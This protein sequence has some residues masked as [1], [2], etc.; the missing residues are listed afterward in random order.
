MECSTPV[1]ENH[2]WTLSD[3][4][5]PLEDTSTPSNTNGDDKQ[6]S[7]TTAPDTKDSGNEAVI[8]IPDVNLIVILFCIAILYL[9]LEMWKEMVRSIMYTLTENIEWMWQNPIKRHALEIPH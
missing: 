4:P 9:Y 1:N 3:K 2:L 6:A 7:V 8:L 5:G